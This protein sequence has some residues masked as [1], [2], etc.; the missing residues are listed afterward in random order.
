MRLCFSLISDLW[1]YGL[2]FYP[3]KVVLV[4]VYF[5]LRLLDQEAAG[6]NCRCMKIGDSPTVTEF[7]HIYQKPKLWGGV[8]TSSTTTVKPQR[9]EALE[10]GTDIKC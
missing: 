10:T 1:S 2:R 5:L 8:N 4:L 6:G 3:E 9:T 7:L